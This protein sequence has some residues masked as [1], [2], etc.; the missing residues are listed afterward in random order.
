MVRLVGFIMFWMAMGLLLSCF[1]ESMFWCVTLILV[2]V[3][4]GFNLFCR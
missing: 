2:L 4:V 3:V 1:I